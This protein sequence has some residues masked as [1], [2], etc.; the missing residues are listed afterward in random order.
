MRRYSAAF[1]ALIV[2]LTFTP[3]I[4]AQST[5]PPS[6]VPQVIAVGGVLRPADGQPLGPRE[7]VTFAIYADQSD[8]TPLWQETQRVHPN[9][10]GRY[11]VFLGA[12]EPNGVP[13]EIFASGEA[14]WLGIA[15]V[16]P[17]ELEQPRTR[18]TSVPYA[19]RAADA[20]TL[21][22]RPAA[23][24]LLATGT[25]RGTQVTGG[26]ESVEATPGSSANIVQ[27]GVDNFL[28]KYMNAGA[29]LGTSALYE[30]G[31]KVGMGIGPWPPAPFDTLH[32]RFNSTGGGFTGYAVQNTALSAS[33]YSGML[34]YDH[35]GALVQ[36]QGFNNSTHEY[37]I[38]NIASGGSI[39]FMVGGA[40][41]FLVASNGNISIPGNVVVG[42][43]IAAKYQD[44]AEW[45]DS[46]EPLEPGTVV[47][48]DGSSKNRVRRATAAYDSAVAG[49]VSAQ[50][51]IKLGE[52]GTGRILVAQSGRVRIRADARYG[53]IRAG[54]LLVTSANPGY[55]M[56]SR[57]IRVGEVLLHRPGTVL[58]KALEPLPKGTG[59]ILV[60]L[61]LQ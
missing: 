55:A 7:R 17:G 46:A 18:I 48:I 29:D 58:G 43:N 37:R 49:A 42:G 59:E 41:R 12:T 52:P 6:S 20:E 10:T 45:V 35:T 53:A 31:G 13:L 40:S 57:P 3:A 4:L 39:N 24:Y 61:T 19:L 1:S 15:L 30:A 5:A 22:G 54:D 26:S 23:D 27:P 32:V 44:V 14:R 9:A 2:V 33:A 47:V 36:F 56:R 38:N 8:A 11:T 28:A 16:R 60:L 50:P 25:A 51:G 34:F 21:G